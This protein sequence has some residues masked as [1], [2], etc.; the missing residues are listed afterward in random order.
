LIALAVGIVFN[1]SR[2]TE[3]QSDRPG[4]AIGQSREEPRPLELG[5]EIE[6]VLA[7][8]QIQRYYITLAAGQYFEVA[9][10]PG[11]LDL[12]VTL[13]G[14]DGKVVAE[15]QGSSPDTTRIS[16]ITNAP[17]Q[18]QL[19][20]RP[21]RAGPPPGPY[22]IKVK[23]LRAASDQDATRVA[24]RRSFIEGERLRLEATAESRRKSIEKF[25]TALSQSRE[26]GDHDQEGIALLY[27]GM[28]QSSLGENRKAVGFFDQSLPLLRASGNH[29]AEA[30]A[31][32]NL[33]TTY[34]WLG[35]WQK[36][37]EFLNQA[38]VLRQSLGDRAGE[39]STLDEIG[40]LYTTLGQPQK[41]IDYH[42]R[43]LAVSRS[44]GD[45]H[46][47]ASALNNTGIAYRSLSDYRKALEYYGQALEI[48]REIKDREAEGTTLTNIG[49]AYDYLGE[50]RKALD[51]YNQA[52]P[53]RHETG[54]RRGEALSLNNA[55]MAYYHL[56]D[57]QK[58][59]EDFRAALPLWREVGD[60]RGEAATLGNIGVIFGSVGE[61]EKAIENYGEALKIKQAVGDRAGE[62]S[63]LTNIGVAYIMI[64]Q[65]EKGL[66]LLN[67]ALPLDR[68]AGD[69]NLEATTLSNIGRAYEAM[70][71]GGK[72]ID[73]SNQALAI[74][75]SIGDRRGEA[76]A[77]GSIGRA[78]CLIGENEK[79]VSYLDQSLALARSV[80]DSHREALT[81]FYIARA[82]RSLGK[83]TDA[84]ADIDAALKMFESLRAKVSGQEL[85]SSFLASKRDYYDLYVDLLMRLDRERP[86]QGFDAAAFQASERAR[87]RSL[88][89]G[90]AE[91]AA[92]IH[93]GVDAELLARER[94][95]QELLDGKADRQM[96]IL[97]GQHTEEQATRIAKDID[98]LSAE[99]QQIEAQIRTSSPRYS[100]L[101][102]PQAMS[103]KQIQQELLDPDTLLL[104]YALADERSFLWA[105]SRDS[106]T[107][108]ELPKR[109]EIETAA[110]RFYELITADA[111]GAEVTE[112]ASRLSQMLLAPA[113]ERLGAKSL[114][115]VSDGAL[116]YMPFA[117]LPVAE[118]NVPGVKRGNAKNAA[119]PREASSRAS[120]LLIEDHEV[121]SLPSA[122]VLA[123]LRRESADRQPASGLVAVLADPVFSADDPRVEHAAPKSER[124]VT[125]EHTPDAKRDLE[126]S[127]EDTYTS[128]RVGRLI[129]TRRE[130]ASILSLVPGDQR[131]E[132][133][134][135]E[136]SRATAAGPDISRYK[137]VHFATHSLLNNRHPEL[138]GIVLSLVNKRGEPQDGFLRLHDIY[139]LKLGAEL[140]VLSACQTGLGK[141][142]KGEGLVGLARGFMYAG[143]ARVVASLW[144][145]DDQA[146]G[147]LMKRFYEGM[148]GSQRLRP[149]QALRA[150]QVAML[151]QQRW[152]SP[153]Y[154]AG[155]VLQ[156]DPR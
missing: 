154:W 107:T 56:S 139:N 44:V 95:V 88:L 117:A 144:K 79:A 40:S 2:P 146:T 70:N 60:R 82:K 23:E 89:E 38:L 27:I 81:L 118:T 113:A 103:L 67:Q 26:V 143:A 17:G 106:I 78:Y 85:R 90:L 109:A 28:V 18:Y 9:V 96:R 86:G 61:Y 87:A 65:P 41:A 123:L 93:E 58:A 54:D 21:R 131:K 30:S 42:G 84:A 114:V 148:F 32:N 153:Y 80:A 126:R 136:A 59:L 77:L 124:A 45:R 104:E 15:A 6:Y 48:L 75:H 132:A 50:S 51:C 10:D 36:G 12:A 55:A 121:V 99:Y 147:E 140:V 19:E 37:L 112:A 76:A 74:Y 31:L 122:S 125:T 116:Q 130:A 127:L 69:R 145:V 105:V 98:E 47:E 94:S 134:D 63:T 5:K 102:Q 49:L 83:L 129:G 1:R 151:K 43:A 111:R 25:E 8:G 91:S 3:A 39:A 92:D 68:A 33:G 149:A 66:A 53:L 100:A 97:A 7:A 11:A 52:L 152:Q 72:S 13:V 57:T 34:S 120:H 155:F 119:G 138:S 62:A 128:L 141:E 108:Y 137:I 73:F 46:G 35:E 14:P 156:G 142:V 20:V 135:F 16:F 133:L 115:F 4:N 22:R 101:T 71:Q 150:A 24:A 110:R 29:R 64:D